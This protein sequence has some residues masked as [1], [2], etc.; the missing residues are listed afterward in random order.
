[1]TDQKTDKQLTVEAAIDLVSGPGLSIKH[2]L[3]WTA[4]MSFMASASFGSYFPTFGGYIPYDS[5]TCISR[6]CTVRMEKLEN[7]NDYEGL[8]LSNG[9]LLLCGRGE[10]YFEGEEELVEGTDFSW[11]TD[12]ATFGVSWGL[13][14]SRADLTTLSSS[15]GYVGHL[16]GSFTGNLFDVFGRKKGALFGVAVLLVVNCITIVS[17]SIY[18]YMVMRVLWGIA[19]MAA[20]DGI[21]VFM[22]EHTASNHRGKVMGYCHFGSQIGAILGP[23]ATTIVADA[24]S[25]E[26][27]MTVF[28]VLCLIAGFLILRLPETKDRPVP[29]TAAEVKRVRKVKEPDPAPAE[30]SAYRV[31]V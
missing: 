23:I 8:D 5:F 13:Y 16:I 2:I 24:W 25:S 21:F 4:L 30:P 31:G 10:D 19:L 22:M 18:M 1:M 9:K 28:S 15:L 14:C 3:L 11:T 29:N 26:G 7:R 12:R 17:V 27:V 6:N 20:M